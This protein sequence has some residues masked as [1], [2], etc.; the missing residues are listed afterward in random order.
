MNTESI[1]EK[2]Q[3]ILARANH[4]NTPQAEAETAFAMAQRLI[5]KHNLDESALAHHDDNN[6]E[7]VRDRIDI[8]GAWALR[9][10]TVAGTVARA[11]SVACYRSDL[12]E[13]DKHGY[14][15][16]KVGITLHLFGTKADIFAVKTIWTAVEMLALRT[17]P[18]GDKSFRNS[19]WHGY[20]V[21]I[22]NALESAKRQVVQDIVNE[23]GS[24]LVLVE[25]FK[26]ADDEMRAGVTLKSTGSSYARSSSGYSAGKTAGSSF[27]TGGLGRGAIGAL[28]R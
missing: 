22:G 28:G 14:R 2:V 16:K 23:G 24:S 3:A 25:R 6:D 17:I 1:I 20:S 18:K 7:V 19:W 26:R 27:N 4:P 5:T 9:R 13:E 12:Y 8:K 21:G 10:C 15:A 11:N